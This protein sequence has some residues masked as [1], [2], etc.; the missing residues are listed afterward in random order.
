MFLLKVV[1]LA[2]Y[3]NKKI[4]FRMTKL[5]FGLKI[6][7]KTWKYPIFDCPQSSCITRYQQILWGSSFEC[8]SLLNLICYTM[9][10]QDCHHTNAHQLPIAV[11]TNTLLVHAEHCFLGHFEISQFS[12]RDCSTWVHS[13]H[14]AATHQLCC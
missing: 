8:K 5:I 6:D 3:L 10:F 7:L 1:H 12:L 9:K 13:L 4:V 2:W 14:S 11:T